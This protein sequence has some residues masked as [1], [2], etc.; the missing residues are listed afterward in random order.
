MSRPTSTSLIREKTRLWTWSDQRIQEGPAEIAGTQKSMIC[1][2]QSLMKDSKSPCSMALCMEETV[3]LRL[4]W[5]IVVTIEQKDRD[6][7][8]L[9][10]NSEIQ[11]TALEGGRQWSHLCIGWRWLLLLPPRLTLRGRFTIEFC[12]DI[13]FTFSVWTKVCGCSSMDEVAEWL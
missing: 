9:V 7:E 12:C 6:S 10:Q 3:P 1:S 5:L 11:G 8:S 13:M 2:S 4:R